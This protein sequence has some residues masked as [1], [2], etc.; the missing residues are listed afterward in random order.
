MKLSIRGGDW[1]AA[2]FRKKGKAS[3]TAGK[4]KGDTCQTDPR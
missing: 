3:R 2:K 1:N 4:T